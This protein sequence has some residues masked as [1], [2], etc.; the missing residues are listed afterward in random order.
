[1]S[2]YRSKKRPPVQIE[3]QIIEEREKAIK[4]TDGT[5]EEY[6]DRQTGETHVGTKWFWIP[7]SQIL[8]LER[9]GDKVTL[10]LP[11]WLA[12]EKGLI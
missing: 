9:E 3:C 4:V 6:Q 1:M 7:R 5:T 10:T 11:E 8:G 12:K 2:R